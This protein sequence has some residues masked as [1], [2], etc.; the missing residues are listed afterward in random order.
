M[1][2]SDLL[3][4][5][6]AFYRE[7]GKY[8]ATKLIIENVIVARIRI[9]TEKIL[10][11][12]YRLRFSDHVVKKVQGNRMAL[13]LNDIGISRELVLKGVHEK[14]STNQF[15]KEVKEGMV[16]LEIG[17][18]IGY[19]TLIAARIIGGQG[20]IYAFEPSPQNFKSLVD[21]VTIN[22]FDDIVEAHKKGLGDKT[23]K[24][25]FFLST[26]SNMSSFL[27]REDMGEIKQVQ[28]I[29]VDTITVDDFLD[30]E[31]IDY[32]RMDVEG[33]EWEVVEGMGKTLEDKENSPKG[34]F[35]EIH[36]E[37][38]KKNNHSVREFINILK[39][40][41]YDIKKS[42]YRGRSDISVDSTAE[43]LNHNLLEKGY[44]ETFFVKQT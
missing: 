21:N 18:N 19:Y 2:M 11:F 5:I 10:L 3:K 23:G 29:E 33:F 16:L 30:G 43:L 15:K 6:N 7:H 8:I 42:F 40:Y 37:L 41:G 36:S 17:A 24:S 35:I 38:L 20:H 31:K 14:N 1:D 32:I 25:K 22:G 34:M 4:R 27:R 44:W 13:S 39:G 9:F 28:T 26:K 12:L